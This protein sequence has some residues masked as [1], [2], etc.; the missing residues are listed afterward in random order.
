MAVDKDDN[1]WV[2]DRPNDLTDIELELVES[3]GGGLL[4]A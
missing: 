4:R 2:L 3:S 1:V